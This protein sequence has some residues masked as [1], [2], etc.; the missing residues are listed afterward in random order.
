MKKKITKKTNTSKKLAPK[1]ERKLPKLKLPKVKLP[2]IK[3]KAVNWSKFRSQVGHMAVWARGSK[4]LLTVILI[5]LIVVV[6]VL[7]QNLFLRLDLT[8]NQQYA[9][10]KASKDLLGKLPGDVTLEIYFSDNLP[11]EMLPVR[12]DVIDLAAEYERFA[13][14]KV[15]VDVVSPGAEDFATRANARGITEIQFSQLDSDKF[16]IAQGYLGLA[17]VKD[18]EAR[19]LPVIT[20]TAGLEYD[21]SSKIYELTNDSK[22]KLAML[23]GHGEKS[24]FG[25]LTL[26]NELLSTQFEVT[27]LDLT[28]VSEIGTD[29]SVLVIA[30]PTTEFSEADRYKLDQYLLSGGKIVVL[31]DIYSNDFQTGVLTLSATN[32]NTFLNSYGL[33]V[34][35]NVLLDESYTPLQSGLR[36]YAYPFW[37]L[38]QPDNIATD[39]P[40]LGDLQSATLFWTSSVEVTDSCQDDETC[41]GR[42]TTL[43]KTT[44]QAWTNTGETV[45]IQPTE[46]IA[47]GAD[48]YDVAILADGDFTSAFQGQE[49][50][51]ELAGATFTAER[52]DTG[53]GKLV[54]FGD[55]DFV[56]DSFIQGNEQNAVL[57]SNLAEWLASADALSAIRSKEISTRPLEVLSESEKNVVRMANILVIPVLLVAAGFGYN[58]L[59][60]KQTN[61]LAA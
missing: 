21:L 11:S 35:S 45:S 50:P 48:Q 44:D 25:E 32:I 14:G 56:T 18:G 13:R 51:S 55:S 38:I 29:I 26:V 39:L 46:F 59:R 47:T 34:S 33:N 6:N 16:E 40:P 7:G 19:A 31:A 41:R 49:L 24:L 36:Q 28:S 27:E 52:K 10:S 20:D 57:F 30:S 9:L 3:F 23:A 4:S 22:L 54:V 12:R 17:V 5:A 8:Q 42:M 61:L 2:R 60:R 43:L 15:T 37:V 1:A 58:A 53:S